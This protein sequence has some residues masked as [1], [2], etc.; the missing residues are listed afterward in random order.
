M[1]IIY[2]LHELG[3]IQRPHS[4]VDSLSPSQANISRFDRLFI[5]IRLTVLKCIYPSVHIAAWCLVLISFVTAQ[6]ANIV[7][8]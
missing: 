2:L 1:S 5:V 7:H 6:L 8:Y 3:R 4:A